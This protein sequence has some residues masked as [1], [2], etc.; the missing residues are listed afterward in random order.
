MNGKQK[1]RIIF[2]SDVEG[3]QT[4]QLAQQM[5]AALAITFAQGKRIDSCQ[6][7]DE[8][9]WRTRNIV[10]RFQDGT[11]LLI[12]GQDV[13]VKELQVG[14]V[15]GRGEWPNEEQDAGSDVKTII[16]PPSTPPPLPRGDE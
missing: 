12:A 4:E 13:I 7:S 6:I 5:E 1:G 2:E 14:E 8:E 16:P 9:G 15:P 3:V 10:I 11:G